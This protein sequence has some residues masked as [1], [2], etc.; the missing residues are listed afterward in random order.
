VLWGLM[1]LAVMLGSLLLLSSGVLFSVLGLA[2]P[3]IS[4]ESVRAV[5]HVRPA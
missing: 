5:L 3:V 4:P 2:R 1:M